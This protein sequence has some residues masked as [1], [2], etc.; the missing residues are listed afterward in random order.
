M[1]PSSR[2]R[3]RWAAVAVESMIRQVVND[4]LK[5]CGMFWKRENAERMLLLRSFYVTG[6]L[7]A[8]WSFA[9]ERR[10]DWWMATIGQHSSASEPVAA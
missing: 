2:P 3:C 8:L 10:V 6:R 1:G 5:G 4:R 9:L 7:D